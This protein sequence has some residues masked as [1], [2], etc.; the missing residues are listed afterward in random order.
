MMSESSILARI[1]A[2]MAENR[3]MTALEAEVQENVALGANPVECENL[4]LKAKFVEIND[5]KCWVTASVR[6]RPV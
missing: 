2:Y 3:I 1:M 4:A 5:V 6:F